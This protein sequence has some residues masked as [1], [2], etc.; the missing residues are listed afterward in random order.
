MGKKPRQKVRIF[1]TL[2]GTG[3]EMRHHSMCLHET[4]NVNLDTTNLETGRHNKLTASPSN[5]T[6][7][8]AYASNGG[9]TTLIYHLFGS[10]MHDNIPVT[11]LPQPSY[12]LSISSFVTG[13]TRGW[14][15][16]SRMAPTST[17]RS[18]TNATMLIYMCR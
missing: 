11:S 14:S 1:D 15:G 18:M 17:E 12:S 4:Q 8:F 2:S 7:P 6:F 13:T 9:Y 10:W 3:T 16:G 5:A